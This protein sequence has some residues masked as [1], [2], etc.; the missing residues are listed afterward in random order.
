MIKEPTLRKRVCRRCNKVY[1]S[2]KCSKY[3]KD[4]HKPS[5]KS[6]HKG[7]RKC[8][9]WLRNAYKR[10][11]NYKCQGC[12]KYENEVGLL[13]IHRLTRGSNQGLYT[14]VPLNHPENNVQVLCSKCHRQRHAGEFK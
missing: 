10:A 6:S 2:T 3:C 5:G 4:C 7:Y 12:G 11:V 9:S 8:P 1:I 13:E 14:V